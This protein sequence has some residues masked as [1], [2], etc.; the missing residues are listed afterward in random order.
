MHILPTG[1]TQTNKSS[2]ITKLLKA[3]AFS[4][5][6]ALFS[7]NI[8]VAQS[9]QLYKCKING[10][11]REYVMFLPTGLKDDA[12]LVMMLH[13][14]GGTA[15]KEDLFNKA[16]Q[17]HGFAVCYP[18][19]IKDGR[20][21]PCWNVGYPFQEDMKVNDVESICKLAKLIQKK[22]HL[23]K[24]N[25]FL[26]GMSN[27]GE[28]C[29]LMAYS[30]QNTFAAVAPIAGLTLRWMY[31]Q[32]EAPSPIPL[33]EIHGTEDRVSEW[34]GDLDNK[35]GWGAYMP[36]PIAVNYWVAKNRCV[37]EK[38]ET[39]PLK[40]TKNGHYVI[41]HKFVGGINGNEVWLYEVVNG[42][43][44]FSLADVDTDEHVWSFFSKY[45]K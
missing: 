44:S 2:M 32:L 17:K 22:F 43:H 42:N 14:Y 25:T 6:L 30:K 33:F 28:M 1:A 12:P 27:G 23:S 15:T 26:A 29:Y 37:E 9:S 3:A 7:S 31:E 19:G 4:F 41:S 20:G 40:N 36:V 18:Q 16:A 38:V 10:I 39:L 5:I 35:G 34:T 13:G 24:K 45:L 21:T 8:C 11:E